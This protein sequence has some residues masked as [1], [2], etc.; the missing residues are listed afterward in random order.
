MQKQIRPREARL[1]LAAYPKDIA[2]IA[3]LVGY[4]S[5]SQ[6]SRQYRRIFGAPPSRDAIQFAA[7]TDDERG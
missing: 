5:P 1:L 7:G 3:Y 2:H 6:F 4:D